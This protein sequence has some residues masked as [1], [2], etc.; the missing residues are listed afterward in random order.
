MSDKSKYTLLTNISYCTPRSYSGLRMNVSAILLT[1]NPKSLFGAPEYT[2][3]G[4][5][6][7]AAWPVFSMQLKKES[8]PFKHV[9]AQDERFMFIGENG[10]PRPLFKGNILEF[11]CGTAFDLI[12]DDSER[13]LDIYKQTGDIM[14]VWAQLRIRVSEYW[15]APYMPRPEFA[16][17]VTDTVEHAVL[18]YLLQS[19]DAAKRVTLPNGKSYEFSNGKVVIST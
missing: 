11:G 8:F 4:F 5:G 16:P 3:R 15:N 14:R 13:P 9:T 18:R 10:V 2:I 7:D 19:E 17:P 1:E 6:P 12:L